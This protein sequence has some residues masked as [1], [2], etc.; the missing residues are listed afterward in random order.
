VRRRF[1]NQ[2]VLKAESRYESLVE[3]ERLARAVTWGISEPYSWASRPPEG[4]ACSQIGVGQESK[5]P[6][7]ARD[8]LR[9]QSI[10]PSE[11]QYSSAEPCHRLDVCAVTDPPPKG[12]RGPA[13]TMFPDEK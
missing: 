9:S 13:V 3:D 12:P 4:E 10:V 11:N 6:R 7:V 2:Q 8:V 5:K 1:G